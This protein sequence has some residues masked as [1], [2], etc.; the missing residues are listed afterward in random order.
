MSDPTS[1]SHITLVPHVRKSDTAALIV[2][3]SEAFPEDAY[4]GLYYAGGVAGTVAVLEPSFKPAVL[5]Y[6]SIQNNILEQCVAAM[7]V[8]VDGTGHSID[9]IEDMTEAVQEKKL[10]EVF[11]KEPY[12]GQ[13]FVHI[14]RKLRVDLETTGNAY[15]EVIRNAEK[16]IML[17]NWLDASYMRLLRYD[18][19]VPVS[20]RITR[21]D[22]EIEVMLRM[23]ERR[24]VQLVNNKAVYFKEFGASREV[25]RDTGKWVE[26]TIPF[27]KVGSEVIHFTV[28]QD[29]KSPYGLPRWIN[30]MPS[31]LG[32]R[33]AE[34]F[35]LDFFDAGGLPPVII[36]IQGGYLGVDVRDEL[37]KHLTT[38][39]NK[40]RA[41]VIEALSSSGSLDS[42]GNVRVS[43]ERF[44]SERQKDAMFQAYDKS[45]EDHVRV[46]FRLAP[47][48]LGKAAD[49]N[50]A[51]AYTA[52]MVTEAQ[53]FG[54]ER[55]EFDSVINNTIC[56]DLG[57]KSYKFR[58][59]PLTLAD[60][61]NQLKAIELVDGKDVSGEEKVSV[62]NEITG[63]SL[64]YEKQEQPVPPGMSG[65]PGMPPGALGMGV[66]VTAPPQPKEPAM[67]QQKPSGEAPAPERQS[68]T[69]KSEFLSDL[70]DQWAG[71]LGLYGAISYTTPEQVAMV[72]KMVSELA[73]EDLRRFNDILAAKSIVSLSVDPAGLTE[74]CGCAT[75][76]MQ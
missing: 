46:A 5:K 35:N 8:N 39:G 62:L 70:V 29:P 74:L 56:R 27:D 20:K 75:R 24:F 15:L 71:I 11:F 69:K 21:G 55:D 30:Q 63:L 66:A 6:L 31:V 28:S 68:A 22:R 58:S 41:V 1:Q 65:G 47:L 51:T 61:Q 9:L 42:S 48:F 67:S 54:P 16:E 34:E 73:G 43:V 38:T 64:T 45:C 76:L 72:K 14:R 10:L 17:L 26:G 60:V 7:E 18:D 44:G 13:S 12:P 36:F 33:K 57:A 19:P 25:D 59:L 53:V 40:N 4:M 32:S 52:Y 37:V 50:F 23:R 3:G 49:F 2:N